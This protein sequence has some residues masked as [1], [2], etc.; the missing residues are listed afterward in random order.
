MLIIILKILGAVAMAI[1][2]AITIMCLFMSALG[3]IPNRS[4]KEVK[5]E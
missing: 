3:L 2:L 1:I 5:E 4:K